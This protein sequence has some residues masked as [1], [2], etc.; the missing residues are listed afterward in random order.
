MSAR[1]TDELEAKLLGFW[2]A[3]KHGAM[4]DKKE[5]M[6][7]DK[8]RREAVLQQLQEFAEE[9]GI[10]LDLGSN[11][12]EAIKNKVDAVRKKGKKLVEYMILPLLEEV[13]KKRAR[14]APGTGKCSGGG[15][16]GKFRTYVAFGAI[17]LGKNLP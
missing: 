6:T 17:G 8:Q 12:L 13:K 4:K 5:I 7:T 9:R 15:G 10:M 2:H 11:P 16:S 1:W 3:A 14:E